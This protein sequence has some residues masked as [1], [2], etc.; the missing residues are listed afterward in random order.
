MLAESQSPI[1]S[2]CHGRGLVG[3]NDEVRLWLKARR[4]AAGVRVPWLAMESGYTAAYI[5]GL[6]AGIWDLTP[7]TMTLLLDGLDRAEAK[8]QSGRPVTKRAWLP[9]AT[10]AAIRASTE[11]PGVL[12]RRFGISTY[13]VWSI[14]TGRSYAGKTA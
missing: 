5:R 8:I 1:C 14:R 2:S 12:A 6:E 3:S 13:R 10:V 11:R 4:E 7:L 9:A